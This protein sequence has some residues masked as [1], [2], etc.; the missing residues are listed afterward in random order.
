MKGTFGIVFYSTSMQW[1]DILK[2][3]TAQA[4][5]EHVRSIYEFAQSFAAPSTDNKELEAEDVNGAGEYG[6]DRVWAEAAE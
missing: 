4:S 3:P 1:A 2:G 6:Q 5:C